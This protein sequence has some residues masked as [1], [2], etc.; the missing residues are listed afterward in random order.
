MSTISTG[1]RHSGRGCRCRAAG[2]A[3]SRAAALR[4]WRSPSAPGAG[5]DWIAG[6]VR[7]RLAPPL[8]RAP[9][10]NQSRRARRLHCQASL[11]GVCG[12]PGPRSGVV[13]AVGTEKRGRALERAPC[14]TVPDAGRPRARCSSA[15]A[16]RSRFRPG[17]GARRGRRT[18]APRATRRKRTSILSGCVLSTPAGRARGKHVKPDGARRAGCRR[19]NFAH[20]VGEQ[21]VAHETAIDEEILRVAAG[22]RE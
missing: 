13:A 7:A 5:P 1:W 15:C 17:C 11:A 6:A 10:A 20:R 8:S 3:R 19:A 16:S 2:R 12:R 4:P 22:A 21:L 18:D 14:G 9:A